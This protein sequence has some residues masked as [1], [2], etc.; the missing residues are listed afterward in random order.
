MTPQQRP[1]RAV[2]TAIKRAGETSPSQRALVVLLGAEGQ[3][4]E[5]QFSG[6]LQCAHRAGVVPCGRDGRA[7]LRGDR[8][9]PNLLFAQP[10][11]RPGLGRTADPSS[12]RD[13]RL[14]FLRSAV[15]GRVRRSRSPSGASAGR[16][17]D[18]AHIRAAADDHHLGEEAHGNAAARRRRLSLRQGVRGD[19]KWKP[20]LPGL[21]G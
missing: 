8:R 2:W 16:G 3:T 10:P 5:L 12:A 9:S 18:G 15:V 20:G 4:D 14:F 17:R 6:W 19:R 13:P 1:G 7:G 11:V 21:G